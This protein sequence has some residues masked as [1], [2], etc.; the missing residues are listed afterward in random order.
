MSL[1]VESAV[2][3]WEEGYRKLEEARS[4]PRHYRALGRVVSAV[5]DQ[6]RQRLGST[7]SVEELASLYYAGTE[8]GL[9]IAIETSP[10]DQALW[11]ASTVVD[12]AFYLYMREAA[13]FAG[14]SVRRHL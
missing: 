8:W 5:Q 14:G 1:S 4:E 3:Q 6:L 12:A 13:D 7:F 2:F 9:E 10:H 11:D